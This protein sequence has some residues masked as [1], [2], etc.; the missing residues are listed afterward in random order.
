RRARFARC[1]DRDRGEMAGGLQTR[2]EAWRHRD[3][4]W[5]QAQRQGRRKAE[6][7]GAE[8]AALT[9]PRSSVWTGDIED[10]FDDP[11]GDIEDTC[12]PSGRGLARGPFR[13]LGGSLR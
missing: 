13:C 3:A 9:S 5:L 11:F 1:D 4:R 10:S 2:P 8:V 12:R 7:P 6:G